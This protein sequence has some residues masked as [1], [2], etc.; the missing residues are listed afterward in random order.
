MKID[1]KGRYNDITEHLALAF[2]DTTNIEK[3]SF[4]AY[5]PLNLIQKKRLVIYILKP[6]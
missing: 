3:E 4:K 2:F 5:I 6:N 1:V